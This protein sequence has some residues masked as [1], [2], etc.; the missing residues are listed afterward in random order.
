LILIVCTY[1]LLAVTK[2]VYL[3]K[4]KKI[5]FVALLFASL[6]TV[7]AQRP[8]GQGRGQAGMEQAREILVHG[9]VVDQLDGRPLPGAHL[10]FTHTRDTTRV[11]STAADIEGNYQMR[12]PMGTYVLR[13]TYLG[14]RPF[15]TMVQVREDVNELEDIK[16]AMTDAM[17]RE[18]TVTGRAI[19]AQQ[20]GDTIQ[21]NASA[22]TTNPDASAED[23]VRRMPGI[24]VDVT[25]I[26]AQG[27]EV[28]RVL[29]DGREFFGD[30]PNIALR[31]IPAEMIDQIEVF[32]QQ[33]DQ[34]LLTGFDDGDR[35]KTINIVTR[36][37]R[38]SGQFGR[39]YSGYG[40]TGRYQAGLVTNIFMDQRRISII[41][42]S[43]NINQQ[44]FSSE[45]LS[46]FMSSGGGGRGGGGG[47]MRGGGGRPPGGGSINRGDFLIGQ[48][49]GNNTTHAL[50]I[51][52]ADVWSDKVQVNGSYFFN[53]S[54]NESEQFSDRQYFIDGN[55]SQ[56]YSS[57][58]Q[59]ERTNQNHRFSGRIDYTI[60]DDHRVI[61]SPRFSFQQTASESYSDALTLMQTNEL[62]NQSMTIYERDWDGYSFS[63]N[64][65]YRARLNDAGR[66]LSTRL[67]MNMNNNEYL[68][69]LDALSQYYEGPVFVED[70]VDQQSDSGTDSYSLSTNLTYTEPVTDNGMLQ[71]SYNVSY[72][73]N[74]SGRMT[75]S[76]DI[77]RESYSLFEDELSSDLTNGYLTNRVGLGY[78]LRGERYNFL[79]EVSYQQADLSSEQLLPYEA[80]VDHSFR[81]VIPML[82]F[83]YNFSREKS[84]RLMYRTFTN[85]PSATQLQDVVDNSNPLLLSSGNPDL[86]QSYSHFFT[87][88]YNHTN[89]VDS[90][91]F[92]AF[93][94][95]NV[96][97]NYIG[98]STFI[99]PSDTVLDNGYK[100]PGGAQFTQPVNLSGH[101]NFRSMVN[102][103]FPLTFIRS[104]MNITAGLAYSRTPGLINNQE[105]VSHAY[106]TNSGVVLSSNISPNVDFSLSYN[107]N[108]NIV[109]NSLRPT[110]DNNY[111][112]HVSQVQFNWIFLD[113]WVLRNDVSNLYYSGLGD[114]FNENY[115]LWNMNLGRKFLANRQAEL[116]LGVY[117]M[118]NQ[119][120]SVQ[121]NVTSN[122]VEDMRS[123]VL[124]RFFMLTLTYN[125]RNFNVN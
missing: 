15:E 65:S 85:A 47:G 77:L 88:R 1:L 82:H 58:D 83:N 55:T 120:Q 27:E 78:R 2:H 43:N 16:L 68:Y 61:V 50:G 122:Y 38:R 72:S 28:Q 26:R 20:R 106:N 48:Q 31:N 74:E 107:L 25:G 7:L 56:F 112:Y 110:L 29:V 57:I 49:S 93:V 66:S 111:F 35:T 37:D 113:G 91:T 124:N 116:T 53:G 121:R 63:N 103:G 94:F 59:S 4:M 109:E 45:D 75:N 99:A 71:L 114:D 30:D 123:N 101:A 24:T 117:D 95:G 11:F 76:W 98:N 100:L 32:D 96:T 17:L 6:S 12:L 97:N 51:N 44:N 39:V 125:I 81:N 9:L 89:L 102:Y 104:N 21:Y 86:E 87:A 119:N 18:V 105:N 36:L 80:V 79:A 10:F 92:F 42:M 108:Y 62:L 41:G 52:Y 5:L 84:L 19:A 13:V 23:L 69:F 70:L 118:L 8:Q 46:G 60:N 14:F 90:R 73:N 22:F 3:P 67:N 34:S 54:S 40:D 115:W 33:S 64:I